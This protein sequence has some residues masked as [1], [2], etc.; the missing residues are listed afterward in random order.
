M[1]VLNLTRG[2]G[3]EVHEFLAGG[4]TCCLLV[5]GIQAGEQGVDSWRNRV[6]LIHTP[7][8]I[9]G[10]VFCIKLLKSLHKAARNAVFLI[11]VNSTLNGGIA[12]YVAVSKILG[13]DARAGLFFLCDLIGVTLG[14]MHVVLT[15]F[16]SV[17]RGDID[18][19]GAELCMVEEESSFSRSWFFEGDDSFLG[20]PSF[21]DIDGGN[22]AAEAEELLDLLFRS[23]GGDVLHMDCVGR[24]VDGFLGGK[25]RMA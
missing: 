2:L 7:G 12:N 21:F 18:L 8:L 16:G 10:F 24:H 4:C 20:L 6:G 5:V 13:N 15:L 17:V 11:E 25:R 22:L 14:I 19:G 23:Y 9:G 1:Y 3:V